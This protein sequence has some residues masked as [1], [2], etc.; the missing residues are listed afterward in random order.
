MDLGF[1]SAFLGVVDDHRAAEAL[2]AWTAGLRL[3]EKLVMALLD[4][5]Y[6]DG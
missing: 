2:V 5:V 6:G 3:A 4:M 1:S